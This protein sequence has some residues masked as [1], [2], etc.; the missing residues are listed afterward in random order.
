V[1]NAAASKI[2]S[3]FGKIYAFLQHG[4]IVLFWG[5]RPY[6]HLEKGKLQKVFPSKVTEFSRENNVLEASPS[7][8]HGLFGSICLFRGNRPYP[9]LQ[10]PN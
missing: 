8:I 5:I 7:N 4:S 3:S 9:H 2:V 10:T 1:L 6:L